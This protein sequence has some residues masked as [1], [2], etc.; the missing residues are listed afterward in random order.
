MVLGSIK[1]ALDAA[2]FDV[3]R[4]DAARSADHGAR[5]SMFL[6]GGEIVRGK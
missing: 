5:H 6:N 3:G 2:D 1:G 4:S